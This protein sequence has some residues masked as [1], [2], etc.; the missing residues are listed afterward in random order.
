[1]VSR[2]PALAAALT[3][4]YPGLGHAYLRR[5][6]RALWWVLFSVLTVM[7]VVPSATLD[8]IDSAAGA[9]TALQSLP[10]VVHGAVIAVTLAA[11]T[12]AYWVAT[13]DDDTESGCPACGK[14]LDEELSFCPWCTE[15]LDEP[16][17][18]TEDATS[19]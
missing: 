7:V 10:L 16:P 4:L 5:W 13:T 18:P 9:I 6:G 2:R 1:M 8:G 15:R 17:E 11:A 14:P 12:D 19:R 3:L